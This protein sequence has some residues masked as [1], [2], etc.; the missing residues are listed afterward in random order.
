MRRALFTLISIGCSLALAGTVY[1]W[2]D[3][4]G[5][6][7]YSDQPHPNAEK[8]QV[9]SAQTYKA[10][11]ANTAGGGNAPAAPAAAA[12]TYQG[13][14]V[15][16]PTQEQTFADID[17]LTVVVQTD[18][19]LRPGD[20]I[21]VTYDGQPLNGNSAT[22]GTFTIS[23]LDRGAHTLQ[24]VVRGA[25]GAVLCQTPGVTFYV[26]QPSIQNPVNPVHP[27]PPPPPPPH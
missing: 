6:V 3:E 5:V 22:G 12:R 17:S 27:P 14:A 18:P 23:P 11:P 4:N 15:V 9:Q 7:H 20:Q 8:I 21:F 26:H 13:C 24:A 16:Q 1:K 10:L 25:D 19:G 2:I